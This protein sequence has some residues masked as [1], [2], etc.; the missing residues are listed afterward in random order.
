VTRFLLPRLWE[1]G[2]SPEGEDHFGLDRLWR[3][4][5]LPVVPD[6]NSDLIKSKSKEKTSGG[7][8]KALYI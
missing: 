6:R 7:K 5:S 4:A 1:Q 8:R 2:I 3:Y